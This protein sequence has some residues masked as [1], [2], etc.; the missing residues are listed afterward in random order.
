MDERRVF[1]SIFKDV[2]I[3]LISDDSFPI[4]G[5]TND[6]QNYSELLCCRSV[7]Q[8]VGN[9]I[10]LGVLRTRMKMYI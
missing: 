10:L 3:I 6:M 7:V 4:I 2:S 5:G 9:I 8:V 1:E